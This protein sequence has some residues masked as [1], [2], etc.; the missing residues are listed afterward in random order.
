MDGSIGYH[1]DKVPYVWD[2]NQRFYLVDNIITF[3]GDGYALIAKYIKMS[4]VIP[5][6][7]KICEK[8]FQRYHG[9]V[10]DKDDVRINGRSV[11]NYK[12]KTLKGTIHLTNGR[13]LK[14]REYEDQSL[15]LSKILLFPKTKYTF[16]LKLE[17]ECKYSM[18]PPHDAQI[19][20]DIISKY[21]GTSITITDATANCGGNT[22]NFASNF[23]KV[24]SVEIDDKIYN[25]LKNN[26][27]VYGYTNVHFFNKDYT[28]IFDKL[29]QDVVFIDPPWGGRGYLDKISL[30]LALGKYT[31]KKLVKNVLKYCKMVV[32]KL[33]KNYDYEEFDGLSYEYHP[34][35]K[36]NRELSYYIYIFM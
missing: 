2:N 35:Y 28:L 17:D 4:F 26:V 27:G 7:N 24:I 5:L 9:K 19:T 32:V 20:S 34:I 18:S 8:F 16:K 3:D 6:N 15:T 11:R 1:I 21:M 33:P 36:R 13:I 14:V 12:Y 31:M 29:V 10:S 25:D 22:L 30:Q 23:K